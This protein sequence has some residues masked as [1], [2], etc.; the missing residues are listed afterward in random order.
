MEA[1]EFVMT[2]MHEV[3]TQSKED[4]AVIKDGMRED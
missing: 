2:Q 4:V 1:L 3:I